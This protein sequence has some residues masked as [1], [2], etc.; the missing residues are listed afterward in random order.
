MNII[1]RQPKKL[2]GPKEAADALFAK[3]NAA[4]RILEDAPKPV[5]VET[6]RSRGLAAK[7]ARSAPKIID[8]AVAALA[9]MPTIGN[10]DDQHA[11][12]YPS[13]LLSFIRNGDAIISAEQ[14]LYLTRNCVH[15]IQQRI[16]PLDHLSAA[17]HI[18]VLAS[19]MSTP[20]AWMDETQIRFGV[21]DGRIWIMDG[22]HRV[23]A[24]S[25]SGVS[26]KWNIKIDHYSSETEFRAAFHKF[27][28]N[29]RIRTQ[30][31]ILGATGFASDFGISRQ[32]A[33]SLF[34]AMTFII[35]EFRTGKS[36]ADVLKSR[37]V[38]TRLEMAAK[39]GKEAA[40]FD[41]C[42]KKSDG[43]VKKKLLIAGV[44][45][46]ALVTLRHR[47]DEAFEFWNDVAKNDGLKKGDPK[48]TLAMDLLTRTMSKGASHQSFAS[49]AT[50]W[51]AF[52]EGR[53]LSI[54]KVLD[55]DAVRIAGT[56]YKG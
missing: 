31:Q 41:E 45:A 23:R 17:E 11:N 9:A 15:H 35:A 8:H 50:A 39:F 12:A 42:L 18:A 51:N 19:I 7:A 38:D 28:T 55:T 40:L 37:V 3:R 43:R 24:Q 21:F 32:V 13:P 25:E 48:H 54:I 6:R 44:T 22:N 30:A 34:D 26:I 29:S 10:S 20:G 33:T 5:I 1:S 36:H 52:Y 14:A 53:S 16:R 4:P 27:N 2:L 46:V 49:P 56:P 47:P